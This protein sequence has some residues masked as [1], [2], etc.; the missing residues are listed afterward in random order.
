MPSDDK[1]SGVGIIGTGPLVPHL[2]ESISLRRDLTVAATASIDGQPNTIL[3]A[4]GWQRNSVEQVLC[5]PRMSV[6]CFAGPASTSQIAS[7]IRSRK[8]VIVENAVSLGAIPLRELSREAV[9]HGVLAV[10]H[11][12][13]RWD[14]DFLDAMSVLQRGGLGALTRVRL[15]IHEQAIPLESFPLGVLRDLGCHWL[16]QLLAFVHDTP[17][18]VQ[19]RAFRDSTTGLDHGFVAMIDFAEGASCVLELQTQSLLSLRTGWLLEGTAGAY[20]AGRHYTRTADGEIIDEP[21]HRPAVSN[22]PFFDAFAQAIQANSRDA[23]SSQPDPA[24]LPDLGHAARVAGLLEQL[25]R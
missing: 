5:D 24:E 20:R 10:S 23:G 7:A 3:P 19:L 12:P 1:P 8:H 6:I 15:S 16:D 13:R 22:D 4:S 14:D 25:Q 11:E 21:V 18:T 17:R 9:D 2:L